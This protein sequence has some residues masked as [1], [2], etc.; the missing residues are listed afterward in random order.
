M[1]KNFSLTE[2]ERKDI[3]EMHKSHGYKKSLNEDISSLDATP[4]EDALS[5]DDDLTTAP[6]RNIVKDA[7]SSGK[8]GGQKDIHGHSWEWTVTYKNDDN[9]LSVST[10]ITVYWGQKNEKTIALTAYGGGMEQIFEDFLKLKN[11][12]HTNTSGG[13]AIYAW[14]DLPNTIE[15]VNFIGEFLKYAKSQHHRENVKIK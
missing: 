1:Y 14:I 13:E 3:M 10:D 4:E 8:F 6:K 9:S 2:K 5:P 12:K 11:K 15:T 7:L